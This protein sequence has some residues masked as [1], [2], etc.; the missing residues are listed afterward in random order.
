MKNYK[1]VYQLEWR[2]WG[3]KKSISLDGRRGIGWGGRKES[4]KRSLNKYYTKQTK[5]VVE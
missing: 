1:V 3:E 4:E 5:P 2:G